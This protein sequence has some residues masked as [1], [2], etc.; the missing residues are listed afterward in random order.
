MYLGPSNVVMSNFSSWGPT[1]DNRVKPDI[2]AQGV[3]VLSSTANSNDSYDYYNGTSMA[4]PGV[5]GSLLL[6]QE[7]SA[8]LNQ[9]EFLRSS[10]LKAII[11]ATALETGENP[12]PDP[13]FGWGLLN[14]EAAAQLMLDSHEGSNAFYQELKLEEENNSYSIKVKAN[15]E[16]ELKA[17]IAWTD[18]AGNGLVNDLDLRIT[19]SQGNTFYPWRLNPGDITAPALN[20]ADNN[21]DNVEKV[22]IENAVEGEEYT[23][24]ITHKNELESGEQEFG[25]AVTGVQEVPLSSENQELSEIMIYPNPATDQI[26]IELEQSSGAVDLQINDLNGRK[27]LMQ[28]I[29]DYS[30]SYQLDISHLDT[31]VYF[32]EIKTKGKKAVKKLIVK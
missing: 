16:E 9:G 24:T 1:I 25:L 11:I 10:T 28:K 29:D 8:D 4:A 26:N 5:A 21:V 32:V 18:I 15:D 13:K 31:G 7:L 3:E 20:D 12:G 23:I 30:S 17:T 6:L 19:D 27:V 14:T 22:W 2:S